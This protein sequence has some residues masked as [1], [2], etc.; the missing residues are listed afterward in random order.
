MKASTILRRAARNMFNEEREERCAAVV[1][2][3]PLCEKELRPFDYSVRIKFLD[4]F[5]N[6][7]DYFDLDA[8]DSEVGILSLLLMAEISD[9]KECK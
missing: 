1:Y 8:N 6:G 7:H 5:G 2:I 3:C 9:S 4:L